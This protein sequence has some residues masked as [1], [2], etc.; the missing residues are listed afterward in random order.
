MAIFVGDYALSF[1]LKWIAL[2]TFYKSFEVES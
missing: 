2:S 1:F